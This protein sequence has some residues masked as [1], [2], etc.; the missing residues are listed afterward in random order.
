M[1]EW[2]VHHQE[3]FSQRGN[4]TVY[5][6]GSESMSDSDKT[7]MRELV[8]ANIRNMHKNE[9]RIEFIGDLS[10]IKELAA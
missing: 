6:H 3:R 10:E 4:L 8:R 5:V 2:E 7:A 9:P 1:V